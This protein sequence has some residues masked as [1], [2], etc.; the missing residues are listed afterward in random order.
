M[1]RILIATP[2]SLDC[3]LVGAV[4]QRKERI[5]V[6]GQA[7]S[8]TEALDM[9]GQCDILLAYPDLPPQG[10][11]ELIRSVTAEH[12]AVKSLV[13]GLPK[14]E[15]VILPYVEAGACGYVLGED[16][17]CEMIEKV[18]AASRGQPLICPEVTAA[19][20]V[21][22]AE[23]ANFRHSNP[24]HMRRLAEL[25]PR[26]REVLQLLGQDLSNRQIAERLFIEVGTV[27]NHV[28]SIL[29]KLNVD[30]RY[31]ATA[32]LPVMQSTRENSPS[33]RLPD[34]QPVSV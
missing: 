7:T 6:V 22:V 9:V 21:R 15:P 28:H 5:N 23:L 18:R 2:S 11:L 17:V 27:K 34:Y 12:P 24:V 14:S 26:E 1:I 30:S 16:S 20:M 3:D 29:K 32:Y 4:L 10:T 8:A 19:L 13:M 33:T 31:D 25:T